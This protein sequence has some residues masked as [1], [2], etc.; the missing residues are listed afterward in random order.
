MAKWAHTSRPKACHP[1]SNPQASRSRAIA[2]SLRFQ[3][4]SDQGFNRNAPLDGH[5]TQ[6]LQ[7]L[8]RHGDRGAF[9]IITLAIVMS[10]VNSDQASELRYPAP[11][12]N[13]SSLAVDRGAR[14]P[15]HPSAPA[16]GASGRPA[17]APSSPRRWAPRGAGRTGRGVPCPP[18]SWRC[19]PRQPSP[20]A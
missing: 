2:F 6:A 11:L 1:R 4:L 15:T 12:R 9:H 7:K 13:A 19:P 3:G 17:P 5:Q 18:T 16:G 20:E 10:P 14:G 8:L